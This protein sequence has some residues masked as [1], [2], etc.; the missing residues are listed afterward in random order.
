MKGVRR[1]AYLTLLP[2]IVLATLLTGIVV[3]AGSDIVVERGE[4]DTYV[5]KAKAPLF[6]SESVVATKFAV[7]IPYERIGLDMPGA[8][9]ISGFVEIGKA[10]EPGAH[11]F[12][13]FLMVCNEGDKTVTMS[14]GY[15]IMDL[16]FIDSEG[17][18]IYRW[19]EG[20][21]FILALYASH[22]KPGDCVNFDHVLYGNVSSDLVRKLNSL[23]IYIAFSIEEVNVKVVIDAVK[24]IEVTSTT[25]TMPDETASTTS[26]TITPPPPPILMPKA[27]VVVLNRTEDMVD[28]SLANPELPKSLT[29]YSYIRNK[30]FVTVVDVS[31]EFVK[32]ITEIIPEFP[33]VIGTVGKPKPSIAS[34]LIFSITFS[35][36]VDITKVLK[37]ELSGL[38]AKG[39]VKLSRHDM[40]GLA[41]VL[42]MLGESEEWNLAIIYWSEDKGEWLYEA[43]GVPYT[44]ASPTYTRK[45]TIPIH[46]PSGV[47]TPTIITITKVVTVTKT[48]TKTETSTTTVTTTYTP[49]QTSMAKESEA[50]NTALKYTTIAGLIAIATLVIILVA[51]SPK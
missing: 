1:K 43:Q 10:E 7:E 24:E 35:E 50:L 15:P 12:N 22:I 44:L 47:I 49:E 34:D 9:D 30:V 13:A 25:V 29:T 4:N 5:V 26:L 40:K 51:R 28:L 11:M 6:R 23:R 42:T 41:D 46:T 27:V 37:E 48:V 14:Y 18:T 3:P 19:S 31:K 36:D 8:L 38:A 33:M 16:E 39:V 17:N 20:K 32:N 2:L 45:V 21:V